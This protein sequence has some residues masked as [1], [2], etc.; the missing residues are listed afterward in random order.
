MT[1]SQ[2]ERWRKKDIGRKKEKERKTVRGERAKDN[3]RKKEK[4]RKIMS[5]R[6][7]GMNIP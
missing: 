4:E 3:V 2:R 5:E 1:K 6:A 7:K